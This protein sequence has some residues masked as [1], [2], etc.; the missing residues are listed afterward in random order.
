MSA[1]VSVLFGCGGGPDKDEK[2]SIEKALSHVVDGQGKAKVLADEKA[3]DKLRE[4]AAKQAADARRQELDK[5]LEFPS[6]APVEL[7]AAC[8][9]V[10]EG[11]DAYKQARLGGDP[12]GLA[13]WNAMKGLDLEKLEK[14]CRDAGNVK[15]ASCKAHAMRT[16]PMTFGVDDAERILLACEERYGNEVARV[17]N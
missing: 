11:Y 14:N 4:K 16:A 9:H 6:S 1:A 3:F 12:D 13:Q 17:G 7:D 2:A 15:V 10:I 5:L 8:T